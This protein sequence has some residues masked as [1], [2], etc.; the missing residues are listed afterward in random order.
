MSNKILCILILSIPPII[1]TG[2]HF[3]LLWF[4]G[5]KEK[6]ELKNIDSTGTE[7]GERE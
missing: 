4:V 2:L 1:V 6:E 7:E 3:F 5:L